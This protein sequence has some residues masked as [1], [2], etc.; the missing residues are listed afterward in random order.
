MG[1]EALAS[2]KVERNAR[3]IA[4]V[5]VCSLA[6]VLSGCASIYPQTATL[7]GGL[8]ESMP[9]KVELKR[10]P[11]YPQV[12]YQCG[13]AAL[14]TA[15][16][17]GGAKVTPEE[18]VP[19][20]YLPERKGSLQVEMLA[21]ARRHGMVSYVLAPRFLD[22]LREIEAGNPVIVLYDQAFFA[23][24]HSWHYAVAVGYDYEPGEIVLRSGEIERQAV[25]F[26]AH[27]L[28]WKGSGYWAMVVMPPDRIPATADEERWLGAIAALEHAGDAA[29]ARTA[30]ANF[31]KRWPQNTGAAVG[32]ANA[33]HALGELPQAE[34]VLR[35]AA[36]RDPDSVVV[37][38]N[39]AQTLSDENR[40]AEALP[41]IERAVALGGPHA[42]AAGET[43][44]TILGRLAAQRKN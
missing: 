31:L 9:E 42:Q 10:V 22:L 36:Q 29:G 15:L 37:L 44:Q 3:F 7:R 1:L 8:P 38:N 16:S 24:W 39:L 32:L 2:R 6:L 18:L 33:H 4:G 19:Q 25:S 26:P 20:V 34:R 40:D 23:P 21:A 11:F 27:E 30:Y 35:E 14:A 28:M 17:A 41:F 12:E 13:P 43:R 5:F